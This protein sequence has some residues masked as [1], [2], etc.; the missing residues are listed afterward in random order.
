MQVSILVIIVC[1]VG[2]GDAFLRIGVSMEEGEGPTMSTTPASFIDGTV[3]LLVF[4]VIAE[5]LSTPGSGV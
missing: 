1:N 4:W 3:D 5:A 2:G